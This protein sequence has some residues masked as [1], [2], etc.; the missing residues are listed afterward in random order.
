MK[1]SVLGFGTIGRG[2]YDMLCAADGMECVSVLVRPGKKDAAFKVTDIS[3]ITGDASVDTVAEVLGGTEPAFAYAAQALRHGKHVVTSNKALVAAHGLELDAIARDMGRAFMFSAACGGGVP[4]LYN[5]SLAV[6]TD[7]VLSLGG[8]LNGTTNYMLDLMQRKNLSYAEALKDAQ[9]LGYAEADPTADVSGLDALRK[10]MLGC[11]VGFDLLPVEGLLN[12]G[13]E[14]LTR[15]DVADFKARR[16][17]CRLMARAGRNE[18][19]G[20]HAYVE[21]VL[22]AEN[23]PECSVLLNYNMARYEGKNSGP[24]VF[25]GQGA[26]RYPTASALLRDMSCIESGRCHMLSPACKSGAANNDACLHSYYVRLPEKYASRLPIKQSILVEN[27]AKVVTDRI[28]VSRMH[29]L[30]AELRAAGAE[31]FFAGLESEDA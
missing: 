20:V 19:G 27:N 10:I 31:L 8:I 30:A 16:L 25:M 12:E 5:L 1:A 29:A 26:G 7:T 24:M 23:A 18:D 22:F 11:A 17:T 9:A 6:E 28:P 21:P 2:V 15:E 14:S 3:E 13:I 4:F